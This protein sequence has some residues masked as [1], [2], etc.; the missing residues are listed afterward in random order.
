VQQ[1]FDGQFL[2]R[3]FIADLGG[4]TTTP[5]TTE[6]LPAGDH[7]RPLWHPDGKQ[8]A[9]GFLPLPGERVAVALIPVA[10][11]APSFLPAPLAGFDV[12][13]AWAPD[14]TFLAVTNY[15]GD[16]LAN[17]GQQRLDVVAPT[18]QRVTVAEGGNIKVVGWFPVPPPPPTPS[19]APS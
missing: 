9:V 14:A 13:V 19:P 15:S 7:L 17:L 4:K 8:L 12:P 6:G 10:G 3:A 16:S 2:L 11:G 1:L 5:I 18:G